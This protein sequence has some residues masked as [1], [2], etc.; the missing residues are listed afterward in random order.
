MN[1]VVASVAVFPGF[2]DFLV[3]DGK[4]GWVTN[5]GRIEKLDRDQAAPVLTATVPSP[6]GAMAVGFGAVW[7]ANCRDSSVYR[8]DRKSAPCRSCWG[9]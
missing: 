7:V 2:A 1:H 9:E 4:A 6:C 3:A 5:R 8:V